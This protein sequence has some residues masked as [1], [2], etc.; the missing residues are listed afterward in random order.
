MAT[1]MWQDTTSVQHSVPIYELAKEIM[2]VLDAVDAA[3]LRKDIPQ[4]R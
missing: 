2:N 1:L 3:S 4:F